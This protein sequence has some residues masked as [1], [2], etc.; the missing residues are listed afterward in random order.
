MVVCV[1]GGY[2]GGG[3]CDF[4]FFFFLGVEG[5]GDLL[6]SDLVDAFTNC[7]LFM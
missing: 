4:S 5:G 2:G 6:V 3:V 1:C 7:S